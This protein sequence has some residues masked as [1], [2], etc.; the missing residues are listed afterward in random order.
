M[1][2][3]P[4]RLALESLKREKGLSEEVALQTIE[5]MLKVAYQRVFSTNENAVIQFGDEHDSVT[6][7]A[8]KTIVSDDEYGDPVLEVSLSDAQ[9]MYED[10][11]LGD[12]LLVE[13]D[14]STFNRGAVQLARKTGK[15]EIGELHSQAIWEKYSALIGSVVVGTLQRSGR[16]KLFVDLE[17]IEAELPETGQSPRDM[18]HVG[19]RLKALV[20]SAE[21]VNIGVKVT[22]SRT[23]PEFVLR[24]FEEEIPELR[25]GVVRIEKIVREAG[26]RSKAAVSTSDP[27]TDPVGA[28]VGLRGVRVQSVIRELGGERMDVIPYS[29]DPESYIASSLSPASVIEIVVTDRLRKRAVAIVSENQLALAIGKQ[30]QNIKLANRL[31]D[32][33]VE[34]QTEEQFQES[35]AQADETEVPFE[36][37]MT[38]I[39]GSE[40]PAHSP[41]VEYGLPLRLIDILEENQIFSPEDLERF[42]LE[43]VSRLS[44]VNGDDINALA[45]FAFAS[46]DDAE[47]QAG[48][49]EV[50]IFLCP[51]CGAEV[52]AGVEVC[53]HCG[54]GL[55]FEEV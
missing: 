19:D 22:L 11:E 12:E 4:F 33:S 9:K 42:T 55:S 46:E 36:G 2:E 13:I 27:D 29:I 1:V 25:S 34:V 45:G 50:E 52:T 15:Q 51:E 26:Y 41:F 39:S 6:I 32:W 8:Q 37:F 23:A 31:T 21:K 35:G 14:P 16:R 3:T 48:D 53:P 17:D 43:E 24:L 44:G 40:I 10:A 47:N 18:F 5:E 7:Y 49:S 30:G 20:T 54:V 38:T 28:C